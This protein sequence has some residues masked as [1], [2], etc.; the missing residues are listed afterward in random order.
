MRSDNFELQFTLAFSVA[1]VFTHS[2]FW[3]FEPLWNPL[4]LFLWFWW[5]QYGKQC[6]IKNVLNPFLQNETTVRT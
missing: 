2:H 3:E 1:L 6:L 4:F 5:F